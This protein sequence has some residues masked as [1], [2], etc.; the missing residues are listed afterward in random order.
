[1][2]S[3]HSPEWNKADAE[4][5]LDALHA[6]ASN[7]D[8]STYWSLFAP[9]AVFL[10]TDAT[11]R[12]TLEQFKAYATPYFDKG[13]GWTYRVV[14]RVVTPSDDGR[15]AWFDEALMNDKYGKCRGSGVLVRA[16]ER[17]P[18]WTAFGKPVRWKIAQYNLSVPIPNELLQEFATRIRE[19]TG[20]TPDR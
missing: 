19:H 7:A 15:L 20:G 10:G 1:M 9:S 17:I 11:E 8:A 4:H 12:W 14:H 6:A 2:R 16:D 13:K 18:L 5:T 3:V